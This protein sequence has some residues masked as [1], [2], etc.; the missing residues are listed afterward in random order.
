MFYR[1]LGMTAGQDR[2]SWEEQEGG[3]EGVGPSGVRFYL[4]KFYLANHPKEVRAARTRR[5][6]KS[7]VS[8]L[9]T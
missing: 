8:V 1:A 5:P 4:A 3:T 7:R 2:G 6:S 9:V